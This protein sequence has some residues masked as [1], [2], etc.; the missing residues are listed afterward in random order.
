MVARADILAGRAVILI[1]IQD[2]IDRQLRGI[3]NKMRVF[4]N[5]MSEIGGDLFRGGAALSV[6]S[7]FPV[8]DFIKFQ[9][10]MLFLQTKLRATDIE[11]GSVEKRIRQLGRSTSFTAKEVAQAA[12]MFAQA[13][14]SI[15]EINKSLQASLDLARGGQVD[16]ST[17]T[18]ILANAMRTFQ[19]DTAR[20]AEFSSKFIAAARLGTLDIVD[21]AESLKFTSGTFAQLGVN[22]DEV[23]GLVTNLSLSGLKASLG[24]TSLNT[25]FLNLAGSAEELKNVLGVTFNEVDFQT[26]LI[27]LTKIEKALQKF[28]KLERLSIIQDLVN[29]R[30]GRAIFG[31]FLQGLGRLDEITEEIKNSSDEARVAAAKLDSRLGG[32]FRRSKSAFEDLM[33][34]IGSTSEGPLTT[35]GTRLTLILNDLSTLSEKNARF[36]QSLLLVGPAALTAG[37]GLLSV[38]FVMGKLAMLMTPVMMLNSTLFSLAASIVSVNKAALVSSGTFIATPYIKARQEAEKLTKATIATQKAQDAIDKKSTPKREKA[39]ASAIKNEDKLRKARSASL[40]Q[41]KLTF[42]SFPKR[43][44]KEAIDFKEIATESIKAKRGIIPLEQSLRSFDDIFSTSNKLTPKNFGLPILDGSFSPASGKQVQEGLRKLSSASQLTLPLQLELDFN[45][46]QSGIADFLTKGSLPRGSGGKFLAANIQDQIK[47]VAELLRKQKAYKGLGLGEVVDEAFTLFE[48]NPTAQKSL[49]MKVMESFRDVPSPAQQGLFDFK[50]A[51]VGKGKPIQLEFDLTPARSINTSKIIGRNAPDTSLGFAMPKSLQSPGGKGANSFRERLNNIKQLTPAATKS[52]SALSGLG[53]V[54]R[55]FLKGTE[56]T[57]DIVDGFSDINTSLRGVAPSMKRFAGGFKDTRMVATT[58][59]PSF[60]SFATT[61]AS[62][63]KFSGPKLV[64]GFMNLVSI[65][66]KFSKI[67]WTAT[68]GLLS[69]LN[70]VRRFAFSASGILLIIE[71]LILFGDRIPVIKDILAGAGKAFKELFGDIGATLKNLGPSFQLVGMAFNDIFGGKMERG[72]RRLK[73]ALSDMGTTIKVGL[74]QSWKNFMINIDPAFSRIKAVFDGLMGTFN[75]IIAVIGGGLSA[76]F[77]SGSIIIKSDG[78][79]LETLKSAFSVENINTVFTML[80]SA[81]GAIGQQLIS[82]IGVIA[83]VLNAIKAVFV[84]ILKGMSLLGNTGADAAL[85]GLK[86]PERRALEDEVTVLEELVAEDKAKRTRRIAAGMHGSA[87]IEMPE[88]DLTRQLKGALQ[89]A[90]RD[91]DKLGPAFGT[92][93]FNI[94]EKG[95]AL[96]KTIQDIIDKMNGVGPDTNPPTPGEVG[97]RGSALDR[98]NALERI[99][100]NTINTMF[101]DLHKQLGVP[102]FI[103]DT[104]PQSNI[105]QREQKVQDISDFGVE[106]NK[107]A[108]LFRDLLGN[109][110]SRE[111][112]ENRIRSSDAFSSDLEGAKDIRDFMQGNVRLGVVLPDDIAAAQE[113]AQIAPIRE[114]IGKA[115][116]GSF[117]STRGNLLQSIP[118]AEKLQEDANKHL[119]TIEENTASLKNP[120]PFVF[121]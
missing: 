86:T 75:A 23:L 92:I 115:I 84:E 36:T 110:S 120:Q 9:D 51:I 85:E 13:G 6:A 8:K 70:G 27:V 72:V 25:A 108:G 67:T 93:S 53:K 30:G 68:K 102:L 24:G 35:F 104:L 19:V 47:D 117:E 98:Q 63:G 79:L 112:L 41:T 4:S 121:A 91:L 17:S 106:F 90:R 3:R 76:I 16:L 44:A 7:I 10:Q 64:K 81:I 58:A 107:Q 11:I 65:L 33:I 26:P 12:T 89:A 111:A 54:F 71:G 113:A 21:L 32:V 28:P 22:I 103:P 94:E 96:A 5:S 109:D 56:K 48:L 119:E 50:D 114:A 97:D 100:E 60:K 77:D 59:I 116:T 62:I 78:S 2:T 1:N 87:E 99:P 15:A 95:N 38:T 20:A 37:I 14:F 55:G 73:L 18:T 29:I 40:L 45:S 57:N 69:L 118:R 61:L 66:T 101:S 74:T 88:T 105:N 34:S 82:M 31:T 43:A 42:P 39:L 83:E 49:R 80:I 52:T 46:P